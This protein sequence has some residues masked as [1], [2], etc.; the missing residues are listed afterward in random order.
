MDRE[1][2]KDVI[3]YEGLYQ[4]SNLGRVKSLDRYVF[5]SRW[6]IKIHKQVMFLRPHKNNKGYKLLSLTK[7]NKSK[8]FQVHRLVAL[9]F[10]PNPFNKE[11][12][13]H[14]NG[15]KDDNRVENLEWNTAHENMKHAYKNNLITIDKIRKCV[16]KSAKVRERP[17]YQI[18]NGEIINEFK[19]IEN[20]K[21][22]L[23]GKSSGNIV[24]ALKGRHK[25][26]YGYEWKYKERSN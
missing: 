6:N 21:K 25:T 13:N 26:A 19:T 12:V 23:G 3:G 18:K 9:A 16:N 2:W 4:V 10:I 24:N 15:I 7:N 22:M 1:I 8:S 11:Q 20:A 5:N 17:I 14:I